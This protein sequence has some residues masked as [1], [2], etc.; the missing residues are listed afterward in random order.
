LQEARIRKWRN[1]SFTPQAEKPV[2]G[3]TDVSSLASYPA[4][5]F[6]DK[7]PNHPASIVDIRKIVSVGPGPVF[8]GFGEIPFTVKNDFQYAVFFDAAEFLHGKLKAVAK[9]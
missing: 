4:V 7:N 9:M 3:S 2:W 1:P 6:L 8:K 5:A